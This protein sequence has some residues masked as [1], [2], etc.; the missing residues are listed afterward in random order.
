MLQAENRSKKGRRPTP[1]NPRKGHQARGIEKILKRHGETKK[2]K[3]RKEMR[4]SGYTKN[5][6]G[7]KQEHS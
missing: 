6:T 5:C 2:R 3:T 4:D 1:H 7:K